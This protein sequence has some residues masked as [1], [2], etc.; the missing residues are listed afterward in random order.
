MVRITRRMIPFWWAK[1][2]STAARIADF[3]AFARAVRLGIGLPRG[4]LRWMR[5]TLPT[6]LRKRS[7]S[8]ER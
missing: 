6:R 2:C 5:L 4:F 3:R 7:F 8:A 1:G